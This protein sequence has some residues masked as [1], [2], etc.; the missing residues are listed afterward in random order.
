MT[1]LDLHARDLFALFVS[2][3]RMLMASFVPHKEALGAFST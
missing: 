2:L 1:S 3:N